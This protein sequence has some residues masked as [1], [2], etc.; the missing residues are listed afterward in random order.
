MPS[1]LP[2]EILDLIL[3][4]LCDEPITLKACCL[5][6]KS[7][8]PWTRRHL[9]AR[10][11]FRSSRSFKF[12][13]KAFPDPLDSPAHY[14]RVLHLSGPEIVRF[15]VFDA[16]PWVR[17][18]GHVDELRVSTIGAGDS[19]I[20]FTQ[21][22]GLSHTL[23]TL[24]LIYPSVTLPQVLDFIC[25]CPLLENLS[26]YSSPRATGGNTDGWD[27][28]RTLPKFTGTLHLDGNNRY[29]TR[30]LLDLPGGLHF[31]KITTSCPLESGDLREELVSMC[32]ETL[33]SLSIG[34]YPRMFSPVSVV[35]RCHIP[36]HRPKCAQAAAFTRPFQGREAQGCRVSVAWAKHQLDQQGTPNRN[37]R[38]P[39][40]DL[41][42]PQLLPS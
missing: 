8:V 6:S 38:K 27:A 14:A 20:S 25:S 40:A 30:K 24:N 5:V 4:H 10:V 23:R 7:W 39:P 12:W 16:C 31:S 17:S 9:F 35:N 1:F 37:I 15:A 41:H 22:H 11:K 28:P 33:E 26:L 36:S 13:M 29:L 32:S 19:R 42:N 21:L 3:H 2:P 18:F 34:H